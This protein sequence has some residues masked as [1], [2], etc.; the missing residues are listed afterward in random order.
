MRKI[1]RS[2][3]CCGYVKSTFSHL[4]RYF[5]HNFS[6]LK[7]LIQKKRHGNRKKDIQEIQ[8]NPQQQRKVCV[9][10][11]FYYFCATNPLKKSLPN[12]ITRLQQPFPFFFQHRRQ[13]AL[14]AKILYSS[15]GE[16]VNVGGCAKCGRF[17]KVSLC[18]DHTFDP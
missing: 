18:V 13:N 5:F 1:K 12:T 2:T 16:G 7:C 14:F 11:L 17:G 8:L 6:A 9:S 10:Q 3:E 4:C 15:E